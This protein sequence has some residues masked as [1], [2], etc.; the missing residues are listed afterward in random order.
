MSALITHRSVA[1]YCELLLIGAFAA[2]L[3]ACG[4]DE[5]APAKLPGDDVV[6][7][8]VNGSAITLYELETAARRTLGERAAATLDAQG[9]RKVPESLVQ[10]RAV[11]QV[12]TSE[13][14]PEE[15]NEIERRVDA[16][17]E[18]LLVQAHLERHMKPSPVTGEMVRKYY[19]EHRERFGG[20]KIVRY[21]LLSS[22][23]APAGD[24]REGLI[25]ALKGHDKNEDWTALGEA[26]KKA[27]HAVTYRRGAITEQ[28]LDPQLRSALQALAVGEASSIIMLDG[29]L[30]V[31]RLVDEQVS[32]ARPLE[33]VADEIRRTLS[34]IRVKEAVKE[35][36]GQALKKA[37]VVYENEE[38]LAGG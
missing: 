35:V 4:K 23:G 21:E 34:P 24:A 14:A 36:S 6:L 19:E 16:Y 10:S 26:M 31:G 17:R 28:T 15:R 3:Y 7:A 8:K 27:G 11:A 1:I 20:V 2:A 33:E 30:H 38:R 29:R 37:S 32:G 22:D 25:R 18:E 9:K 5:E 12:A 13:L